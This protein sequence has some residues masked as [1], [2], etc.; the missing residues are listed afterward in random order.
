MIYGAIF[1][2]ISAVV[3]LKVGGLVIDHLADNEA[4]DSSL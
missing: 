3:I 1:L 4:T 2:V